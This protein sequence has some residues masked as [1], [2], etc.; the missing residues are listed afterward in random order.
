MLRLG[1]RPASIEIGP[2]SVRVAQ[3][4][5]GGGGVRA[6]R[7]AE[8]GLP[9]GF[10]WEI[11]GERG[12]LVDAIKEA[13]A[14]AG[15]RTR[16][17]IMSLPRSQ[18]T[19]RIGAFPPAGREDMRRVVEYDLSDH[20]P[21]PVDQVIVDFQHLGPS[22]EQPGLVDV[23]VVAAPRELVREYLRL[24]DD[25]GLKVG[26]LTVEAL[27]LDDLASMIGREPPGLGLSLEIGP[28]ATTINVSE[29]ERLRLT[30]SVAIGGNQLLRAIREDLGV[31]S[32]EAERRRQTDGFRLASRG[33]QPSA[34]QAWLDNLIGEMRRSALSFGPAALSRVALVGEICATPE[35]AERLQSEFGVEPI[36]LS[37]PDLFPGTELVG[38]DLRTA[39]R[40][41]VAMAAGGRAVGRSQWTISLLPPE[42]LQVRRESR[43]RRLTAV[44]GAVV[45]AAMIALYVSSARD[46]GNLQAD[47]E[48]RRAGGELAA[49]RQE[50][51]RAILS[52]R[53]QLRTRARALELIQ[54]RR[55]AALELLRTIALYAPQEIVLTH[56][57]L[58]PD[59]PLQIRGTA[60]D[61]TVVADLQ[62]ELGRSPLVSRASLTSVVRVSTRGR[63][64]DRLSF[65]MEL[66]LWTEQEPDLRA[67][68]IMPWGGGR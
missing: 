26:A 53:D 51:A 12:P 45:V 20:I 27:A 13:L 3:V 32:Q 31:D 47:V 11:G 65:T 59:Q 8:R 2:E 37:A 38:V 14:Q 19:A 4:I 52:E 17:A 29:G 67:A 63:T 43:F 9:D 60:P 35:L 66:Q 40:C 1:S 24:A 39:D 41:L 58:R 22:R 62:Q 61:S 46:V 33:A 44:V 15:I 10:R 42:V 34:M 49:A 25:L 50:R 55:Y 36:V 64:A 54:V 56:F 23:L 30:R 18:V 68:S 5:E 16:K 57:T 6:I 21:F 7:F 28:R 48:A